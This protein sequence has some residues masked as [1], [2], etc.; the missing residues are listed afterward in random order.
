MASG[1]EEIIQNQKSHSL[2]VSA[3]ICVKPIFYGERFALTIFLNKPSAT[4]LERKCG[5]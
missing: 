1:N 3:K 4:R 2:E 5:L